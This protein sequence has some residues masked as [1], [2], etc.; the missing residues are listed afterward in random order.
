MFSM[1]F[2]LWHHRPRDCSSIKRLCDSRSRGWSSTASDRDAIFQ[3][4]IPHF[5]EDG[6]VDGDGDG[7]DAYSPTTEQG[8]RWDVP[9][10]AAL[11]KVKFNGS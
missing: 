11:M 9:A 1:R 3:R 10:E 4:F 7:S 6:G 8:E 2:P 5:V